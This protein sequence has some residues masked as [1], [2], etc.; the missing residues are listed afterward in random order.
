MIYSDQEESK[1]MLEQLLLFLISQ[2]PIFPLFIWRG[3]LKINLV[4][5]EDTMKC[6][7]EGAGFEVHWS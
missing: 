5:I 7:S 6:P 3:K 2:C 1:Q 4:A